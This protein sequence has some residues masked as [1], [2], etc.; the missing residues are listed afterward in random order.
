MWRERGLAAGFRQS[1][2]A[3]PS[4]PLRSF[5]SRAR[6][7]SQTDG[8]TAKKT[9]SRPSPSL[10][11]LARGPEVEAVRRRGPIVQAGQESAGGLSASFAS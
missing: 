11:A 3:P 2:A 8:H 7:H 4:A 9:T 5:S 6:S 1:S 10:P